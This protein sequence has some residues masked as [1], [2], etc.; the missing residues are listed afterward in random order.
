MC[1]RWSR[2]EVQSADHLHGSCSTDVSVI[3]RLPAVTLVASCCTDSSRLI[4]C[5][6]AAAP[7]WLSPLCCLPAEFVPAT[8]LTDTVVTASLP[9]IVCMGGFTRQQCSVST[10][11]TSGSAVG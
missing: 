3:V 5:T 8:C 2:V 7:T 4:T 6:A 1:R 11:V 9:A 10:V